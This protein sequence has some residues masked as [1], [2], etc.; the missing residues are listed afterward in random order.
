MNS[1]CGQIDSEQIRA[2]GIIV[3]YSLPSEWIM[4]ELGVFPNYLE[5][6]LLKVFL[7]GKKRL[8][9]IQTAFF[10]LL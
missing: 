5:D 7:Q 2:R 1:P 6:D 8:R 9:R 10:H 4:W 3:K